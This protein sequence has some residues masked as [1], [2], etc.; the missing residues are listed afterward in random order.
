MG[1]PC[2]E[3]LTNDD[4]FEQNK[5]NNILSNSLAILLKDVLQNMH[6]WFSD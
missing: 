1:M 5:K 3:Y 2:Y 6:E 4:V